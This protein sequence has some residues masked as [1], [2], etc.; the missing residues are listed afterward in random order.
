MGSEEYAIGPTTLQS[1]IPWLL[2]YVTPLSTVVPTQ[3]KPVGYE[4]SSLRLSRPLSTL[5]TFTPKRPAAARTPTRA[6]QGV[7][8]SVHSPQPSSPQ[9]LYQLAPYEKAQIRAKLKQGGFSLSTEQYD[10]IP[11][12]WPINRPADAP[13]HVLSEFDPTDQEMAILLNEGQ[14]V[15]K[16]D[17]R[18]P[19]PD[20]VGLIPLIVH[21]SHCHPATSK[22]T[23]TWRRQQNENQSS[24]KS[25]TGY[26]LDPDL[27]QLI[28]RGSR[29]QLPNIPFHAAHWQPACL[30]FQLQWS[31]VMRVGQLQSLAAWRSLVN[32]SPSRLPLCWGL[33]ILDCPCR[34]ICL[35]KTLP[36]PQRPFSGSSLSRA[37]LPML[38]SNKVAPPTRHHQ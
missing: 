11:G 25:L 13:G 14:W 33:Q 29:L 2:A 9:E 1:C 34:T 27:F 18:D 8:A 30:R 4:S 20:T 10:L 7:Q 16:P 35:R 3:L 28:A 15:H 37:P 21:K 17:H 19:L 22:D 31:S 26:L 6:V 12:P 5:D 24:P 36:N 32:P 38:I 23:N